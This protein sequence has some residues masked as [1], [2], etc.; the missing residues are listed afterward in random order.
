MSIGMVTVPRSDSSEPNGPRGDALRPINRGQSVR[1][2]VQDELRAFIL[3]SSLKPHDRLPPEAEIAEQLEVS[4]TSVRE[5][6]KGLEA[7][8]IVESRAGAGV[9]VR[10]FSFS[11]IL[12]NL[13]YGISYGI[14]ELEEILDV[15]THIETSVAKDLI[16]SVTPDQIATLGNVLK[17]MQE[18]ARR[19]RYSADADRSFHRVLDGNL[20]NATLTRILD[21][22]WDIFHAARR[23]A[24][25]PDPAN[26]LETVERHSDILKALEAGDEYRLR[27]VLAEHTLG[28]RSRISD[29]KSRSTGDAGGKRT[30]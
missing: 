27:S 20:A 24:S 13:G 25:I 16:A 14:Q 6:I 11:P 4:R 7:L 2:V 8:G 30:N 15:R 10:P 17:Q 22:F 21:I 19:G 29:A 1:Q 9:F 18:E 3:R 12:D 23:N 28:V 5:A 26:P